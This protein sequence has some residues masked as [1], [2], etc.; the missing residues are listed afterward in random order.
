MKIVNFW[1]NLSKPFFVLAPMEDVT[2]SAF[3][4]VIAKVGK[5]DV[6]FTEF[7]NVDG[8]FSEGR[9]KVIP[10]LKFSKIEHPIVAQIWGTNL[11]NFTKAAKLINE[12]GFDG[13]DINMGCPQRSVIKQNSC[14]ALI[15]D[16]QKAG[17]IFRAVKSGAS[18][19]PVSIKTRIGF[20]KIQTSEWLGFLL[21]LEPDALIV[22]GRTVKEQSKVPTH[23]DE[24]GK[25]VKMRDKFCS[26]TLI[27]GNGDI[28][29][30]KDGLEKTKKYKV[31]GIMIGRGIFYNPWIFNPKV[32]ILKITPEQRIKILL[33]HVDIFEKTW[34][35]KKDFN[36]MKKFFKAYIRDFPGALSL[37]AKLMETN[38]YQEALQVLL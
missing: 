21:K 4:Q 2:D 8:L 1:Q 29:S 33:E 28:D 32:D 24:I 3:R 15:N 38:N 18:D 13:I 14:G 5:P 35:D 12:L 10:R 37:R 23:W 26:K 31:D 34:G 17:E 22:H 20:S 30:F 7:L 27:V 25:V 9:N 11:E 19:L 16:P 36:I 6:F